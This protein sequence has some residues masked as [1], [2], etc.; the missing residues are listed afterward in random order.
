[1]DCLEAVY[2][3]GSG[4]ACHAIRE[5]SYTGAVI[6]T[7]VGWIE[8]TL[9]RLCLRRSQLSGDAGNKERFTEHW[10]RV[11]RRIPSGFCVEFLFVDR[12]ERGTFLKF[13]EAND[14]R[15]RDEEI[16]FKKAVLGGAG[17]D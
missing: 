15:P 3:D 10:C 1:V 8:G 16:K 9:I 5:I 6:E 14:V 4:N 2:W 13:L 11:V 17:T 7:E 12:K